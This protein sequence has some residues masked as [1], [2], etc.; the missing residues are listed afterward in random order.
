MVILKINYTSILNL[1]QYMF[2]CDYKIYIITWNIYSKSF[3]FWDLNL[4]VYS[5]IP[6]MDCKYIVLNSNIKVKIENLWN[7][8]NLKWNYK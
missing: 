1:I 6:S 4:T 7:L 2:S 8:L 5:Y 3:Y